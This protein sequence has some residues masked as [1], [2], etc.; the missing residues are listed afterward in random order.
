MRKFAHRDSVGPRCS[1]TWGRCRTR[2]RI[3]SNSR[4]NGAED[5]CEEL[6]PVNIRSSLS[7]YLR[8]SESAACA[9]SGP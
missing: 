4:L 5:Q 3:G 2:R 6:G 1:H 8:S 7:T 9:V